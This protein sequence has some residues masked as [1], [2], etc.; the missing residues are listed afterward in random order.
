MSFYS[1]LAKVSLDLLTR[2]GQAVTRREFTTGAYD[3]TTGA[4]SQTFADTSRKGAL[5]AFGAGVTSVRGQLIQIKD[6]RLLI[7]A[8]GTI[9]ADDNF[10][11]NGTEYTVVTMSEISPAGTPVVYDLHIRNG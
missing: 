5:F 11:V 10:I 4:A 9:T 8:T 7:D 2:F 1:D 6:K 3:P